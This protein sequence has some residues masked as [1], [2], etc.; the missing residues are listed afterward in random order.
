[1]DSND[2]QQFYDELADEYDL[3]TQFE[4]RFEKEEP[5]F[6]KFVDDFRL[7]KVLDAGC[8]SGFHSILL[9]KLG[10]E[11]TAVDVSE[12]MLKQLQIN[13]SKY[14]VSVK[15]VQSSFQ[16]ITMYVGSGYDAVFCMGNSLPHLL[17]IGEIDAA[18]NNFHAVLR[19]GGKLIL[20]IVNFDR[21][22]Y[23]K[24]RIQNI[25]EIDGRTYVRYYNY[26]D[27]HIEFNIQISNSKQLSVKLF[28]LS[29]HLLEERI[30]KAQFSKLVIYGSIYLDNYEAVRSND[31]FMVADK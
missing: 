4:K 15:T 29:R 27:T 8:G 25:R 1:M 2:I 7:K 28:P 19:N 23:E 18:L 3:M 5:A 10:C 14:R 12:K 16:D 20:Q 21:I 11:V 9:A 13:S 17:S 26:Y 24:K 22:L 30:Y 31:L 6:K